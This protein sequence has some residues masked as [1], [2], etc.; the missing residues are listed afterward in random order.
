MYWLPVNSPKLWHCNHDMRYPTVVP[1]R[2]QFQVALV[3]TG[4]IPRVHSDKEVNVHLI[5]LYSDTLFTLQYL[6]V[7]FSCSCLN[8]DETEPIIARR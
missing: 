4:C 8:P 2:Q 7:N 6:A 3:L 1:Q 5:I